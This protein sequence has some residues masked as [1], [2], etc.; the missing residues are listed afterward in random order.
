MALCYVVINMARKSSIYRKTKDNIMLLVL[1]PV[2]IVGFLAFTSLNPAKSVQVEEENN[3]F[4]NPSQNSSLRYFAKAIGFKIGSSAILQA[5][6]S[7]QDYRTVLSR[8]FNVLTPENEMKFDVIHPARNR[9]D[10]RAADEI[11]NFASENSMAVRGHTLVW[12]H[13]NPD[14]LT[15]GNFTKNE[16]TKILKDHVKQVVSHYQG[17]V[18]AW[19]VV[20]EPMNG[21]GT[22]KPNIWLNAIGPEYIPMIFRWAREADPSAKLFINDFGIEETNFKSD[23][24]YDLV[25]NWR[26]SGVPING[27]GFQ[28]HT[29]VSDNGGTGVGEETSG[30]ATEKYYPSLAE[31]L[32]RFG[33]LGL[34][35]HITEMDAHMVEPPDQKKL[36]E[37]AAR[38]EEV[39][40][41]C[42]EN[43]ATCKALVMWGFTD[44]YSW[45][46]YFLPGRG[47]AL[48]F[49]DKYNP[50]PAYFS[51]KG[52]LERSSGL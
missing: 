32:R 33:D 35:I 46:P 38:Y 8:E 43:S 3:S 15:R 1:A 19:D 16:F 45:I 25:S 28:F 4:T 30:A 42:L 9:Y 20:N 31:N 50:K 44:K 10:F 39:L 47:S 29:A 26:N 2:F 48:I 24:L 21:D 23:G 12:E 17:K 18:F 49:D 11:V 51:L 13:S 5:L 37:Q 40:Q 6:S 52:V 36:S 22:L 14:W 27:I 41:T 34:E 7:E